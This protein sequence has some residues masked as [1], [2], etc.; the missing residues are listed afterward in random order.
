MKIYELDEV[1]ELKL[2][3]LKQFLS[4]KYQTHWW[5]KAIHRFGPNSFLLWGLPS[6]VKGKVLGIVGSN[7]VGK[8]SALKLISGNLKPNLGDFNNP[9]LWKEILK[10]F[11]GN[12]MQSYLTA[13]LEHNLRCVI[14]IQ[15]IDDV[16][17]MKKAQG[18]VINKLKAANKKGILEDIIDSLDM[19]N[20]LEKEVKNLQ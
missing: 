8:T 4:E 18:I 16:K 15:Y 9:P 14:K 11:R 10:Y 12:D 3:L 2:A 13:L 19:N 1:N 17:N 5:N 6:P 7:G 20:I